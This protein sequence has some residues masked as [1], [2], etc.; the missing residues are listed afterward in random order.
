MIPEFENLN[1]S[2]SELMAKAPILVCILIAGADGRIDKKEIKG[3]LSVASKSNTSDS[4]LGAYFNYVF[5]D[6]EDK[7]LVLM[8]NYPHKPENR[9]SVIINELSAINEIL[10]KINREFGTEFYSMLKELARKTAAASGGVLG[11]NAV[12][13]EEEKLLNLSMIHPPA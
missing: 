12:A 4:L 11:I 2:E 5:Q 1:D 9:T 3:A 8:Q 7:I 6:F 13:P 10:P